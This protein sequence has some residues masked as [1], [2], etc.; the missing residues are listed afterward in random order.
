MGS[1]SSIAFLIKH[2]SIAAIHRGVGEIDILLFK[3]MCNG[4]GVFPSMSTWY[5]EVPQDNLK[6]EQ[7]L[8]KIIRYCPI[9]ERF[10]F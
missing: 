5:I 2:M 9:N 7:L 3:N 6:R 1:L 8:K 10:S 4:V